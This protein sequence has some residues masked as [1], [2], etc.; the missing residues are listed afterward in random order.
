MLSNLDDI[1]QYQKKKEH[2]GL[3]M[4]DSITIK[5][6]GEQ[7]GPSIIASFLGVRKIQG[8]AE[9]VNNKEPKNFDQF[10]LFIGVHG[11]NSKKFDQIEAIVQ[12]EK[13]VSVV[14]QKLHR[15]VKCL[16][17]LFNSVGV[18]RK[19]LKTRV[20]QLHESICLLHTTKEISSVQQRS[21]IMYLFFSQ[22]TEH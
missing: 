22:C 1:L 14:V 10:S 3:V 19:I 15:D 21:L 4:C 13:L 9:R 6:P 16:I 20:I 18:F 12:F 8:V 17:L 11:C 7:I 5:T 2:Q